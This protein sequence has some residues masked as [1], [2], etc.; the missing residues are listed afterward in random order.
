[1][2][3]YDTGADDVCC[4]APATAFCGGQ[5]IAQPAEVCCVGPSADEDQVCA[6]DNIWCAPCLLIVES[7]FPLAAAREH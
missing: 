1:M 6:G 2:Y 4:P 7:D 5:C 3:D